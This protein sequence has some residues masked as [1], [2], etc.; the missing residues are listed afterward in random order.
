MLLEHK[1]YQIHFKFVNLINQVQS[2]LYQVKN[3]EIKKL[4][5]RSLDSQSEGNDTEFHQLEKGWHPHPH[6]I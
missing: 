2:Y 3:F 6:Q 5:C 1:I 4:T